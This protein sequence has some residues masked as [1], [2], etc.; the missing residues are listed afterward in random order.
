MALDESLFRGRQIK[1]PF[2][3]PLIAEGV[4]VLRSYLLWARTERKVTLIFHLS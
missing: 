4:V 2:Y 3:K 1:V